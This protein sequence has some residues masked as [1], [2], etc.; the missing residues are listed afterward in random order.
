[1]EALRRF[2]TQSFPSLVG[3][4]RVFDEISKAQSQA[5]KTLGYPPYNIRKI[6]D[7][8]YVIEM[9]V[10]GFGKTDIEVTTKNDT[11]VIKG[12]MRADPNAE[13]LY[14]GIAERSFER[15]FTLADSVVVKNASMVNGFLRV[16]LENII[17]EEKKPRKVEINDAESADI[18]T[19]SDSKQLLTEDK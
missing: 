18:K 12:E 19:V 3:F 13:Y 17:P 9:A 14:K 7:D 15:N 5:A 1:M 8:H 4:D 6:D 2:T 16:F 10:A 11:L